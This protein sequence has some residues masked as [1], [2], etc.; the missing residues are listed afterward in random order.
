MENENY[1][2]KE[3]LPYA[4]QNVQ[5]GHAPME[6]P[7]AYTVY[8]SAPNKFVDTMPIN[9]QPKSPNPTTQLV[10][11]SVS[12]VVPKPAPNSL[13]YTYHMNQSARV[14]CYNC[15]KV[16]VTQIK[17]EIG[18]LTHLAALGIALFCFPFCCCPYCIDGLKDSSHW[19]PDCEIKL[20]D[21]KAM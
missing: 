10:L 3:T 2:K 17:K 19:C 16:V 4:G 21:R 8:D 12:T 5:F 13:T 7:P 11:P 9:H 20:G 6:A 18:L 14:T 15:E 1:D